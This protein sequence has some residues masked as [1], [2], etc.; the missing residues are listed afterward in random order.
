MEKVANWA[1]VAHTDIHVARTAEHRTDKGL[2]VLLSEVEHV[3]VDEK[4][5]VVRSVLDAHSHRVTLPAVLPQRDGRDVEPASNLHRSVRGTVAH[6]DDLVDQCT[7]RQDAKDFS[8]SL[9]FVIG[10]DDGGRP[11]SLTSSF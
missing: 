7:T 4:K 10:R 2:D 11:Q 6:D 9:F 5:N 3:A 8:E 1:T